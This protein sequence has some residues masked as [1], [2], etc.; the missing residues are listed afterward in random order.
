MKPAIRLPLVAGA[1]LA[2]G[3]AAWTTLAPQGDG[4]LD[5]PLTAQAQDAGT[6]TEAAEAPAAESPE[7]QPMV[8]G[9]PDAPVTMIEYASYTCPHCASFHE[10]VWPTLKEEYVDT[11]KVRFEYREVFFDRPGLWASMVARCG[12]G[13]R[14]F[15]I[16]ELL[17]ENQAEWAQ[18]EPAQI[19]D[20]LRR[21][22]LSAGLTEADLEACLSDGATAQALVARF[23]AQSEEDGITSTPSFVID[24]ELVSNRSLEEFREILDAELAEAEQG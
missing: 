20:G 18:G 2:A 1:V 19:A 9:E 16:T 15:G 4:A 14:F 5:L 10:E 7:I 8:L 22:G 12:G 17:Y 23:E 13:M 24:G 11:G 3:A 6:G 21:L